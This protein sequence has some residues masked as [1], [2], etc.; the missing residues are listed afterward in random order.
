MKNTCSFFVAKKSKTGSISLYVCVCVSGVR[1][2]G[3]VFKIL[4][5]KKE[6]K[7]EQTTK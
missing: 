1:K 2:K 3:E 7:E 6:R 4:K 5:K